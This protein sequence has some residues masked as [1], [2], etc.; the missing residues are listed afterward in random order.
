[1]AQATH[2]GEG[3]KPEEFRNYAA[4]ARSSVK[5]F[6]RLNHMN[7]TLDFVLAKKKEYLQMAKHLD[8]KP[9]NSVALADLLASSPSRVKKK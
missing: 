4:E 9:G 6:Y 8:A 7:Q 5:E 1:M 3:R 2:A